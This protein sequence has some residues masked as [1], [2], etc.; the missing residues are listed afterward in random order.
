[1]P[2]VA[3]KDLCIDARRPDV[4]GPFWAD[5]LGLR[6]LRQEGGDYQLVG[7]PSAR[8]IWVNGVPEELTV[9]S[10][11]HLDVLLDAVDAD[12]PGATVLQEPGED[13]HWRVLAD[14]DGVAFCGFAPHP[15]APEMRGVFELVVDAHDPFAQATWWAERI[16][17]TV[18]EKEGRWAWIEGAEGF[19]YLFWVFNPV[20]ERKR[21]KNRVHWDVT[22]RDAGVGDVPAAGATLLSREP[23]WTVLADPEGN[24]F[25]AF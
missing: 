13:R 9:K 1:M 23:S 16:G 8:T 2:D 15:E 11:V 7:E 12:V 6:P 24:E 18:K 5:L 17:G 4:V 22:M 20:Q 19:P 21:V 25:C 14:P 10:R 3:F